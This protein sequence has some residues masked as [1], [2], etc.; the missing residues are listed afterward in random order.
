MLGNRTNL[1]KFEHI[2]SISNSSASAA[3]RGWSVCLPRIDFRDGACTQARERPVTARSVHSI[4]AFPPFC[5]RGMYVTVLLLDF[6]LSSFSD[7][8]FLM[9]TRR[10]SFAAMVQ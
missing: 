8:S 5:L 1:I 4:V 6:Y 10:I 3:W 2:C 9:I 7:I